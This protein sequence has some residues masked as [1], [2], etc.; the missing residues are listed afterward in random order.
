M[1]A[2]RVVVV[3]RVNTEQ[4][5]LTA[6][7]A[8]SAIPTM[9]RTQAKEPLLLVSYHFLDELPVRQLACLAIR[10][11]RCHTALDA[12]TYRSTFRL[13]HERDAT[14]PAYRDTPSRTLG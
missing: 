7:V 14:L 10:S 9:N 3:I 4:R 11:F 1:I 2:V 12:A 13:T 6:D 5:Q 8:Q